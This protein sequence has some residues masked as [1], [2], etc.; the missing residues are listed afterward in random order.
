[1]RAFGSLAQSVEQRTFNPLVER[2][3]RSRPTKVCSC[4]SSLY[5]KSAGCS[6]VLGKTKGCIRTS[7]INDT[8]NFHRMRILCQQL[9]QMDTRIQIIPLKIGIGALF[10]P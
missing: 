4:K 8:D 5:L 9:A 1:M 10:V 2:S 6:F 7:K 3:N